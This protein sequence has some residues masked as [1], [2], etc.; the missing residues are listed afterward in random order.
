M[1]QGYVCFP[2]SPCSEPMLYT[3]CLPSIG[4]DGQEPSKHTQQGA[5][6]SR[7]P[8]MAQN[9][10]F[11]LFTENN[12]G[13]FHGP[14][15]TSPVWLARPWP[16]ALQAGMKPPSPMRP[17]QLIVMKLGQTQEDINNPFSVCN[18]RSLTHSPCFHL[19]APV[20]STVTG[21]IH[22]WSTGVTLFH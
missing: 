21:E 10:Y 1:D 2:S 7:F 19:I 22:D 11:I 17:K 3:V 16:L 15:A 12:T 13:N 5:F 18:P 6:D 9:L 14:S 8:N 20:T 4:P